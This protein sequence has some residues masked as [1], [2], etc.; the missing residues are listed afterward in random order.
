MAGAGYATIELPAQGWARCRARYR[1]ITKTTE[2]EAG[3]WSRLL[4]DGWGN[5]PSQPSQDEDPGQVG[6]CIYIFILHT[7]GPYLLMNLE[8]TIWFLVKR[9]V[10]FFLRLGDLAR[11]IFLK[12]QAE[13]KK[14]P[15]HLGAG[16]Y[17]VPRDK[18]HPCRD[19]RVLTRDENNLS[20][21]ETDLEGCAKNARTLATLFS[22]LQLAAQSGSWADN[23]MKFV[24]EITF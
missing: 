1:M 13:W 24:A 11:F 4:L 3:A 20:H 7:L 17:L 21:D 19:T 2:K 14:T 15:G 6:V 9:V 8:K 12:L 5:L 18:V 22:A 23:L 10:V 16:S